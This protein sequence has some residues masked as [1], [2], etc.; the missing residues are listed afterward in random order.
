MPTTKSARTPAGRASKAAETVAPRV[1]SGRR[2]NDALAV[3][4]TPMSRERIVAHAVG[5]SRTETLSDLTIARVARELGITTGL[6]HYF[7]GS[8]DELLSAALNEGLR[9]LVAEF[10]PLTGSWRDDLLS[11]WLTVY[12]QLVKRRGLAIYITTQSR[13]RLFQKVQPGQVDHGLVFFDRFGQIFKSGGFPAD[14]AAMAYH[15]FAI[16]VTT[17]AFNEVS[18]QEPAASR[19]FLEGYLKPTR[20]TEY[21]GAVF[22]AAG[23][24]RVDSESALVTGL[25]WHLEAIARRRESSSA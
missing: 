8:R 1:R 3:D 6:V 9:E 19:Q 12:R 21:P 24:G 23:I 13:H 18:G 2:R 14:L 15:Q 10:P 20:K 7:V 17:V 22:L 16:V 11:H 4:G 25:Q 5:L